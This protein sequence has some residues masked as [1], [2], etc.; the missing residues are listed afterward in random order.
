VRRFVEVA[1]VVESLP[2]KH[3]A[4][5]SNSNTAKTK[6][7][8]KTKTKPIRRFCGGSIMI[9]STKQSREDGL[10]APLMEGRVL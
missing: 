2:S 6:Q 4:L 10:Q 7:K 5:S 8:A 9:H 3:E 1:E